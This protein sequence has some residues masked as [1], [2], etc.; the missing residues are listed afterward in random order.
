MESDI[1]HLLSFFTEYAQVKWF[2]ISA[3]L[4]GGGHERGFLEWAKSLWNNYLS[5]REIRLEHPPKPYQS[6]KI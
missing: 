5:G 3:I 2:S 1:E 6:V 4:Y